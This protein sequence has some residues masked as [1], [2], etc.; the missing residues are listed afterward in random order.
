MKKFK[1][2]VELIKEYEVEIDENII[3]EEFINNFEEYM[4]DLLDIDG[5]D[6]DKLKGLV[7]V[8]IDNRIRDITPEGVGYP[9]IKGK[10]IFP[11]DDM[12]NKGINITKFDEDY[13]KYEIEEIE[14]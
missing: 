9:L 13:E 14:L 10:D 12:T 4:F 2:N 7:G 8:V 5:S 11:N 1:V 3:N 6:G